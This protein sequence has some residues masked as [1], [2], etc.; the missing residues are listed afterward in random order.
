V[1]GPPEPSGSGLAAH[2]EAGSFHFHPSARSARAIAALARAQEGEVDGGDETLRVLSI[3]RSVPFAPQNREDES[4]RSQA[5]SAKLENTSPM[6]ALVL[7]LLVVVSFLLVVKF[8]PASSIEGAETSSTPAPSEE[9]AEEAAATP[10][11]F[12]DPGIRPAADTGPSAAPRVE[13]EP[14]PPVSRPEPEPETAPVPAPSDEIPAWLANVEPPAPRDEGE[15]RIA[16]ALVHGELADVRRAI[17]EATSFPA[18]RG[19][20][21]ESFALAAVD[22]REALR[23]AAEID[24]SAVTGR[25]KALLQAAL[26]GDPIEDRPLEASLVESPLVLAMEMSLRGAEGDALLRASRYPE[27][28]RAFSDLLLAELDAPWPASHR[29]LSAWTKSL[30]SAQR[31]HRWNPKGAWP[32]VEMVVEPGDNAILIRKRFL[33]RNPGHVVCTGQ[34]LRSNGVTGYLQPGQRLRVPTD[35]VRMLVDLDARWALYLAGDEVGGSWPVGIGR[36]GEE[37][38]PGEYLARNKIIEPSWMRVGQEPIPFGD[39]RNPLGTR[40][41]G[42]YVGEV[43]TSYGFHGANEPESVGSASSDGCIRLLNEDVETLFEILPEG[44]TILVRE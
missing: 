32:G 20:L 29:A 37:T 19:L 12:L 11:G 4:L 22:A 39:R 23:V 25:E 31:Y 38:P 16:A 24:E 17:R 14:E 8:Y 27:A 40:W 3:R 26:G 5:N 42:W 41:I 33:A 35:P 9:L 7:L 36:E 28:A 1:S 2:G 43:K 18:A 10:V 30:D 13:P 21:A 6:R 15:V 44:A 34:I